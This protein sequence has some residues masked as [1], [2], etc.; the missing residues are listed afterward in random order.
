MA[1]HHRKRTRQFKVSLYDGEFEVLG[2]KAEKANLSKTDYVRNVILF[3]AAKDK[4][5]FSKENAEKLCYEL[6]RIGNNINQIAHQ[7]NLKCAVS[8]NDF[9]VLKEQ[10][11]KVIRELENFISK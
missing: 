7:A 9:H 4:T 5:N 3:G 10:F 2:R 8:E 11:K 6:N 1:E